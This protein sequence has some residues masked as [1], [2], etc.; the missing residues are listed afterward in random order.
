MDLK[1]SIALQEP[2]FDVQCAY[3][4][5]NIHTESETIKVSIL[6]K[7]LVNLQLKGDKARPFRVAVANSNLKH[8]MMCKDQPYNFLNK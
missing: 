4:D 1:L 7:V 2:N 8:S 3:T 6:I 5:V